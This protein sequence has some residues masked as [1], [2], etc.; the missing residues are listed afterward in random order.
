MSN[1]L[2][3]RTYPTG[4]GIVTGL[5]FGLAFGIIVFLVSG[6]VSFGVLAF[7]VAGTALG[8]SLERI[9]E[10]RPPTSQERRLTVFLGIV[11]VVAGGIV[12]FV[13]FN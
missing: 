3:D 1:A 4:Y 10:T 5:W 2:N 13:F 8:V 7:L 9:L 11:G 12:F 6:Q